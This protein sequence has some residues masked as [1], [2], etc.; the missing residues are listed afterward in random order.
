MTRRS[1]ARTSNTSSVGQVAPNARSGLRSLTG[2]PCGAEVTGV[3]TGA[4]AGVARGADLVDP[5][6]ERIAVA[7]QRNSAD[8]LHVAA[9]VTL[10][11][12]LATAARPERHPS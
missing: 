10:A 12:V 5:H 11:P 1:F 7:V 8:T 6:E 2:I 3:E 9:G 4:V